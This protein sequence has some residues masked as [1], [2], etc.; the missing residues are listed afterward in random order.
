MRRLYAGSGFS[1]EAK[2]LS[3]GRRILEETSSIVSHGVKRI[4]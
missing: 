4:I 2:N 3:Y 1:M